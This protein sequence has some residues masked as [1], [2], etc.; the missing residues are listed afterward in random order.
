MTINKSQ[1][2]SLKH[3][4][5]HLQMFMFLHDQLYTSISRVTLREELMILIVD[6]Y[7]EYSNVKCQMWSI[8]KYFLIYDN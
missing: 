7:G 3:V 1:D 4:E 5:I 6:K 8:E 2:Q